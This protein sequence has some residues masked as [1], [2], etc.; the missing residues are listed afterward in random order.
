MRR[1]FALWYAL[2]RR[3]LRYSPLTDRGSLHGHVYVQRVRSLRQSLDE[4]EANCVDGSVLIASLLQAAGLDAALVRVPGHMFLRFALDPGGSSHAYLETTLLND[5]H[6]GA[7]SE[8][9]PD[10][11][12]D[13]VRAASRRRFD[14][15]LLSGEQ[16]FR[17]A[18]RELESGRS[19]EYRVI[20]IAEARRLGVRAIGVLDDD[21][22]ARAAPSAGF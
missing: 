5:A 16:Q 8:A 6:I 12:V 20:E 10:G 14:A 3:G 19:P 11:D 7:G 13:P 15:A 18:R 2:E 21:S 1:V 22:G 4:R 9:D 17:R